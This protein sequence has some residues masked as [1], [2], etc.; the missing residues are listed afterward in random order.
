MDILSVLSAIGGVG[1]LATIIA[2]AYWLGGKFREID[3]KFANIEK[4]FEQIDERFTEVDRRFEAIDKRFTGVDER[5]EAVEKR[6]DG[7]ERELKRLEEKLD[8]RTSELAERIS[9]LE[10]MVGRKLERLAVSNP[11]TR[12][13]W[14]RL[15]DLLDKSE[16]EELSL[17]EAQELLELARKAVREY[18]EHPE[19]WKLHIYASMMLG[20]AYKRMKE[21]RQQ[22]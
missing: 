10:A 2:L 18:G 13:G 3:L 6:L 16:K 19:A 15:A 20:L 5:F 14:K 9:G 12:E 11:F 8:S 7:V 21:Q 22:K 17:E 4:R 1:G